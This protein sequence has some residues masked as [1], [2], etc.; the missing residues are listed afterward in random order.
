MNRTGWMLVIGVMVGLLVGQETIQSAT[1]EVVDT[2]SPQTLS[3][4]TFVNVGV[5]GSGRFVYVSSSELQFRPYNGNRIEIGGVGRRIPAAGVS[6]ATSGLTANTTYYAYVWWDTST[7]SMKGELSTTGHITDADVGM[8]V[9]SG[10]AT[11]TLVGMARTNGSGQFVDSASQQFVRSWFNPVVGHGQTFFTASHTTTSNAFV[12]INSEIRFEFVIFANEVVHATA[13][14]DV[15]NNS[16]G[17]NTGTAIGFDGVVPEDGEMAPSEAIVNARMALS[18][19]T[20]KS[21]LAE[22]YHYATV[23]GFSGNT[24]AT[25][26]WVGSNTVADRFSLQAAIWRQ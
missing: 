16:V 15:R 19:T 7:T 8:E 14:G 21:G 9:K 13:C 3:N 5:S 18:V 20:I 6:F 17:Q 25:A 10:D 12:E 11:R 24:S 23:L 1:R 2:D 26:T 4:K 22:G